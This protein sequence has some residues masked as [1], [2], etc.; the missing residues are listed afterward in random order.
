LVLLLLFAAMAI[1]IDTPAMIAT[2]ADA[3]HADRGNRRC[4]VGDGGGGVHVGGVAGGG[5]GVHVGGVGGGG[6]G[7][8]HV[9]GIG[10]GGVSAARRKAHPTSVTFGPTLDR[11]GR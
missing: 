4:L 8:V 9:G 7:G 10:G 3:I 6:G 1:D 2:A 5:V 11:W